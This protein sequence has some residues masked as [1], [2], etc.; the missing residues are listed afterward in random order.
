MIKPLDPTRLRELRQARKLTQ[1]ALATKAGLSKETVYRL[2]KGRQPGNRQQ[3]INGLAKGLDVN[4]GVLTGDK[5][6]PAAS[7]P[8]WDAEDSER[9]QVNVRVSG[10]VRNAFSLTAL[11][12][13]VPIARIVELAPLLFVLAAEASLKRRRTELDEFEGSLVSGLL[14][15]YFPH[16]PSVALDNAELNDTLQDETDSIAARDILAERW[17]SGDDYDAGMDNPFVAYLKEACGDDT[18]IASIEGFCRDSVNIAVCRGHA[19]KLA[20][21]DPQLATL[22]IRGDALLHEM[23]HDLLDADATE[24]RTAWLREKAEK[25][26]AA[27]AAR[28]AKWSELLKKLT[29][30]GKEETL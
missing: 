19:L 23:P 24:A 26:D 15:E 1:E 14:S 27:R 8:D 3:T 5:P 9:Y 11:R 18:D 28:R 29:N 21:G 12:Y 2:E 17:T 13:D 16:L 25:A 4:P 30:S 10:T 20:G 6:M 7:P 22:I